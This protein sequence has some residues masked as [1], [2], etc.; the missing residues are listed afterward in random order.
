MDSDS[1]QEAMNKFDSFN[2]AQK[3][4]AAYSYLISVLKLYN[5]ESLNEKWQKS[6]S[7]EEEFEQADSLLHELQTQENSHLL[8]I[9][10]EETLSA[11]PET[12]DNFIES[13]ESAG[14]KLWVMEAGVVIV[15]AALLIREIYSRGKSKEKIVEEYS[16][17]GKI[18]TRSKEIEYKNDSTLG[19]FLKAVI[20]I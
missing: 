5:P 7:T 11:K 20:S 2:D 10:I 14:K 13:V 8:K 15:G 16:E 12:K 9:A 4:E 18:I 3:N 17:D 19:K 6:F 1:L